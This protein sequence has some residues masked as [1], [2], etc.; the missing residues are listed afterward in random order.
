MTAHWLKAE[1]LAKNVEA[2]MVAVEDGK[3]PPEWS[4]QNVL[5]GAMISLHLAQVHATLAVARAITALM[6]DSHDR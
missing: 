5:E 1:E 3:T 6:E 2:L 4:A